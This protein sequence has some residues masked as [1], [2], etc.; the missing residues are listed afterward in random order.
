MDT[1]T[2]IMPSRAPAFSPRDINILKQLAHGADI[3]EIASSLGVQPA[4]LRVMLH[5]FYR[6]LGVQN[7]LQAVRWAS[8][9]LASTSGPA[10]FIKPTD[11]QRA[12]VRSLDERGARLLSLLVEGASGHQIAKRTGLS[13]GTVRV[14]LSGL[15]KHLGVRDR[16]EA[17]IVGRAVM[18]EDG[19]EIVA[20]LP[21]VGNDA[22]ERVDPIP[23][24]QLPRTSFGLA[25]ANHGLLAS[26]GILETYLGPQ[27][28]LE[29]EERRA[30]TPMVSVEQIEAI[31][32]TR[33]LWRAY[34]AGNFEFARNLQFSG[35]VDLYRTSS[36]GNEIV[37][38]CMLWLG[39]FTDA[40]QRYRSTAF[41]VTRPGVDRI[42]CLRI[43]KSI[44]G[45]E[46]DPMGAERSLAGIQESRKLKGVSVEVV[47]IARFHIL[48]RVGMQLKAATI[49]ERI[50]S[51]AAAVQAH[52]EELYGA[53][54]TLDG[55]PHPQPRSSTRRKPR[56]KGRA[57]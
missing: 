52:V 23:L 33:A 34:L 50:Y 24:Q 46:R 40:A 49:A 41:R 14:Y 8:D 45:A 36:P 35:H 47:D 28:A 21:A 7:R 6:R 54:L 38:A 22:D 39:G 37:I 25:A 44:E 20:P 17:A 11:R 3:S 19:V 26:L 27:N 55:S 5:T 53:R 31:E 56:G 43:C 13:N 4:S 9:Y 16:I 10:V 29:I 57:K 48:R 2:P 32:R 15:Y 12:L 18:R 51:R 1:T 30:Q 42:R